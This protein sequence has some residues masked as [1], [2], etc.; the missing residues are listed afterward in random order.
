MGVE[1]VATEQKQPIHKKT[2]LWHLILSKGVLRQKWSRG[3][4]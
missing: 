3:S 1:Q 4:R 2:R